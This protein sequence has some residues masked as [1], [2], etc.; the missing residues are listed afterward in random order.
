MQIPSTGGLSLEMKLVL[1]IFS[2]S[3]LLYSNLC[4]C[5]QL[6][7]SGLKWWTERMEW[8][9]IRVGPF[10]SLTM[11]PKWAVIPTHIQ[12]PSTLLHPPSTQHAPKHRAVRDSRFH[13]F[14]VHYSPVF[15]RGSS[16]EVW[17]CCCSLQQKNTKTWRCVC[18]CVCVCGTI[19]PSRQ[20]K[21]WHFMPLQ[22][23][24]MTIS[25]TET[26]IKHLTNCAINI[27]INKL[28]YKWMH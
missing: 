1:W 28:V 19:T 20:N 11:R 4:Q 23:G 7:R 9:P 21:Y 12:Q 5:D 16:A 24:L 17:S 27:G 22:Y 10:L 6:S 13:Q 15:P 26:V 2:A 3:P 18:V 25:V 8:F 14:S